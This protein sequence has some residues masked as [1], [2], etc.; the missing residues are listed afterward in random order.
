[1]KLIYIAITLAFASSTAAAA[2]GCPEGKISCTEWC[3][4]YRTTP[5]SYRTCMYD[6]PTSSCR[7]LGKSYCAW[8]RWH[9]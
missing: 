5:D 7:V 4:K 6:H 9:S 1:M 2:A 8:D 3:K